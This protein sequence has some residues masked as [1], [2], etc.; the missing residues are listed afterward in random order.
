M[1]G[2]EYLGEILVRQG[3]VP[4]DRLAALFD[5][6]REKGQPLTDLIVAANLADEARIA[7][8][9]AEECGAPYL[10]RIDVDA[11]P[12]AVASRIPITYAKHH[13]ILPI[14]EDDDVVRCVLADP[15][16]TVAIDDLRAVFGKPVEIAVSTNE[17][18]LNAINRVWEKKENDG[19]QLEG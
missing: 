5:T 8:A 19:A 3:V 2:Q 14:A 9:L 12:L 6:V 10:P 13:R 18:V 16:D 11:V 7:Q 4:P 1:S 17:N 15:L